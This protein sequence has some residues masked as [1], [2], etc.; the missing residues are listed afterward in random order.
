MQAPWGM[1][2]LLSNSPLLHGPL[3]AIP[4]PANGMRGMTI[5]CLIAT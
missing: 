3:R 1:E 2:T 4:M 5:P